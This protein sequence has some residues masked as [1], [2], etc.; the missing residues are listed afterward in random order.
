MEPDTKVTV[1]VSRKQ[2]H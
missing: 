2:R 1:S